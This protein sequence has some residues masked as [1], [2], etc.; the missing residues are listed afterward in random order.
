VKPVAGD[1][2][3]VGIEIIFRGLKLGRYP[4]ES[5]NNHGTEQPS[6]PQP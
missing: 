1:F 2:Y 3:L 5:D 4:C 6:Q